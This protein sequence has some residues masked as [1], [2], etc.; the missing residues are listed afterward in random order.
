MYRYLS[1]HKSRQ[2]ITVLDRKF[3]PNYLD[4]L[5]QFDVIYRSPGIPYNLPEIQRVIKKG[6]RL[7]SATELFFEKAKGK[8]IGVTGTK[9]KGTTSALIYKILKNDGRDAYLAGNIGRPA[10]TILNRLRNDSVTVLELSSFQLQD[11]RFS[12]DIAV[13]L[14]IFPDHMDLHKNLRE[15]FEAKVRITKFQ[16]KR[17]TV[18][19]AAGNGY[20]ERIAK[21]SR[22]RKV[23]VDADGSST[24]NPSELKI[25]GHHNF[26]NVSVAAAVGGEMHVPEEV[27]RK[28]IVSY[29]GLPLRLQYIGK[30]GERRIYN[31]SASTNS[32]TT[33]AAIDAFSEPAV[34][35]MGGRDKNLDFGPVRKALHRSSVE[36]VIVYGECHRKIANSIRGTRPIKI[37]DGNLEKALKAALT[38]AKI[39]DNIVFSPGAT[40]FDMFRD[41]QERGEKFN[42][43]VK[44]LAHHYTY[45]K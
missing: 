41:Y 3:D 31:D 16:T 30:I 15:Y 36:S 21:A 4:K 6:V 17:D 38:A 45:T 1:R 26:L 42:G 8:I 34:I 24:I 13:V 2:N 19:Y 11:L 35:I 18:V 28:T 14:S 33:V 5:D 10:I 22:G 12:P 23:R 20:A 40:S 27:I 9:G 39:A 32:L 44:R 25:R 29:R 43:I 7:S 37:V